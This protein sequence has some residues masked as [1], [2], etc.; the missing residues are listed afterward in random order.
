MLRG[1]EDESFLTS[2]DIKKQFSI[3]NKGDKRVTERSTYIRRVLL[4]GFESG[5]P[6]AETHR[7]LSQVFSTETPSVRAWFQRFKAGSKKLE[8]EPCFGRTTA[9][10]SDE[11]KNLAEQLPY[12]GVRYFAASF[13]CSLSTA[14]SRNGEK[15]RTV[16]PTLSDGNRQR[17][18]L[19]IISLSEKMEIND[20]CIGPNRTETVKDRVVVEMKRINTN[21][22]RH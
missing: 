7:N 15:A 3:E 16:A 21:C 22:L 20:K 17:R 4:Y 2:S 10:S 9:I 12:E 6:A 1:E 14:I 19:P 18:L 5:H 13:S 8:D 11:L